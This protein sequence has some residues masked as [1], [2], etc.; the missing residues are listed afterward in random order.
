MKYRELNAPSMTFY[1]LPGCPHC[2]NALPSFREAA[3]KSQ[4]K[5][6]IVDNT[7]PHGQKQIRDSG[8]TSFPTI[9]G[10]KNNQKYLYQGDRS[11]ESFVDF[12]NYLK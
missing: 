3:A 9:V 7:T 11:S 10:T 5:T 4:I 1:S 8:I 12:A 2:T 6:S